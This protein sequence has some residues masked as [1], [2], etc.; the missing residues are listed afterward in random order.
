L[1][2]GGNIGF[3][4]DARVGFNARIGRIH[5][6]WWG[7]NP[8]QSEYVS[9]GSPTARSYSGQNNR[10]FFVYFG[11]NVSYRVYNATLQGQFKDSAVTF[12]EDDINKQ[13]IELWAGLAHQVSRNWNVGGFVR[14]RS[15]DLK[16]ADNDVLWGGLTVSRSM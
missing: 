8:Q 10:D 5:S 1:A 6:P 12:S 7:F 11:A 14:S 9:Q 16:D 15:A 3:T 13:G 2:A 4:T